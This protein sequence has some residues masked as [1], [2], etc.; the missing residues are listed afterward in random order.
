VTIR[1][2][3]KLP[4]VQQQ[5]R[6]RAIRLERITLVVQL[7]VVVVLYLALGQS[8]AMKAAWVDDLL[9]L[10]PPA[11]FLTAAHFEQR[12]PSRRFPYGYYRAFTSAFLIASVVLA[13]VGASLLYD[14]V[15]KLVTQ[16]RTSIGAV[17]VFGHHLWLGWLMLAALAY[18]ITSEAI[19]GH[20][21]WPLA[22][23]LHDK[24]LYA[25]ASMNRAGWKSESA[26]AVGILGIGF[27]F[28]WAD[29]VAASV[30][31]VDILREGWRNLS[32]AFS[33][34]MD[35]SPRPVGSDRLDPLPAKLQQALEELDWVEHAA[36]RLRE[37][38][39]VLAG[40]A[41]VV[42]R[43]HRDLTANIERAVEE[44][45]KLDWRLY[46]LTIMP[47]TRL[48]DEAGGDEGSA[49]GPGA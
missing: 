3:F 17:E 43:G 14:S 5:D 12:P 8:Q 26:A 20:V 46:D 41:F 39:H 49:A 36:V 11:A 37:E 13:W 48:S 18:S 22:R 6:R 34:L 38:G 7:S 44:L 9:A 42:A 4:E 29:A 21:K 47:V 40:E 16:E 30:I 45:K 35:A 31:A 1:Q 33:D 25:D 10:V 15:E 2:P 24:V 28:W 32:Q 19:L 23:R 27:G